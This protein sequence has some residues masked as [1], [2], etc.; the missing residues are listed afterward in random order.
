MYLCASTHARK[1]KKAKRRNVRRRRL[2]QKK[3]VDY[4]RKKPGG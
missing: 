2:I 4:Y 1:G 3:Q